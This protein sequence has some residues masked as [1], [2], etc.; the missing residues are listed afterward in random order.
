MKSYRENREKVH[1][2]N[3]SVF[4]ARDDVKIDQRTKQLFQE[5][6][7]IEKRAELMR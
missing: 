5:W 4:D 7:R 1:Q 6:H 3:Q 2:L